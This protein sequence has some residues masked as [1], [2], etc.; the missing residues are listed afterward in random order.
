MLLT[1]FLDIRNRNRELLEA[2]GD[3]PAEDLRPSKRKKAT[4]SRA[5]L[6]DDEMVMAATL[7]SVDAVGNEAEEL[8]PSDEEEGVRRGLEEDEDLAPGLEDVNVEDVD[9]DMDSR[10]DEDSLSNGVCD[11]LFEPGKILT[12]IS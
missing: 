8:L 1:L 12:C 2:E 6:S 9:V 3:G 5:E 11:P 7:T 4:A 10:P